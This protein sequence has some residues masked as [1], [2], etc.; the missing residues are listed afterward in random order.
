MALISGIESHLFRIPL[1]MV[2]S[3]STHGSIPAFQ[4][5]TVRV[6]DAEGAEGLGYTYTVG[7]NG[8]AI[9]AILKD[10]MPEMLIG[11][12]ADCIESLWQRMWWGLHY[13][14]RGGPP[15]LALS[16]IDIALWDLK[17]RR[18]NLPLWKLLGGYDPRVP[19]YMGGVDLELSIDELLQQTD[20]NLA[21]GFRAI[22]MKVGRARLQ[23]D[24]ERVAQMRKHLG[25]H[26]PLMADA[27]MRWTVDQSILAA[28]SLR[29]Q[30]LV[31]LEEPIVPDDV[32]GHQRVLQEGGVPI[33]T[34]ENLRTLAEFRHL[35]ESRGVSFPEP[36]VTSCGGITG[37]MKVAHLAEA[38]NLPVTSHGAHDIT[39]H[40]M[41]ACPNRA[42]M[43]V[44]SFGLD[45]YLGEGLTL[46]EGCA[47]ASGRPGHGLAFDWR[48]L[49]ALP[50]N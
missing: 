9:A 47:I 43:E 19:C 29:D 20:R 37:F 50:K 39:V 46:Q 3:D 12:D 44:H 1:P 11:H 45:S 16:A 13:G 32:S 15:V 49:Q 22:K 30:N 26:F 8:S 38:F 18:A 41:A 28:R 40:L 33:A 6:V 7:R 35:I 48:R 36:D 14:G 2:L 4:L 42:Y 31:W 24:V 10:E 27:N 25:E 21:K 5:N 17:A 23:E 34:G